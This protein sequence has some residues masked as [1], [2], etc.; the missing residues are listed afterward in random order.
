MRGASTEFNWLLLICASERRLIKA[1]KAPAGE[2]WFEIGFD[3]GFDASSSDAMFH[4]HKFPLR[5]S[6]PREILK[7]SRPPRVRAITIISPVMFALAATIRV[8]VGRGKE[9]GAAL[10]AALGERWEKSRG[11]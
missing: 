7:G 5:I 9:D 4:S 8:S 10:T 11:A 3:S 2:R 1:T 6:G